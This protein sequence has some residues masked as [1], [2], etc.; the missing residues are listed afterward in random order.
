MTERVLV[1][2]RGPI[3][4]PGLS[5]GSEALSMR[6]VW[7][8]PRPLQGLLLAHRA[9]NWDEFRE[10]MSQL[11]GPVA[12]RGLCRCLRAHRLATD[13]H[14]APAETG[15]RRPF[16]FPAGSRASAGRPSRCPLT[17]AAPAQSGPGFPRH[18]QYAAGGS[19]H[20]TV[21]RRRLDRRLSPDPDQQGPGLPLRLE[22]CRYIDVAMRR[23]V[24]AVGGDAAR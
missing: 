20:R 7:L 13:R 24:A 9:R 6:A 10:Y 8:D 23:G 16:R 21:P 18:G 14:G 15:F 5:A 3:I 2:P 4:S 11:A 1:T 12:K 22:R 19:W 17:D